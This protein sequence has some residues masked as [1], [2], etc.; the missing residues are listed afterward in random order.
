[1]TSMTLTVYY[2]YCGDVCISAFIMTAETR[3]DKNCLLDS[4]EY[5][6]GHTIAAGLWGGTDVDTSCNGI[7]LVERLHFC[8]CASWQYGSYVPKVKAWAFWFMLSH[9]FVMLRHISTAQQP[10]VFFF[11]FFFAIRLWDKVLYFY[12]WC[13]GNSGEKMLCNNIFIS[14]KLSWAKCSRRPNTIE[15]LRCSSSP[16]SFI[17]RRR[18]HLMEH[19]PQF[20]A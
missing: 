9:K 18:P 17:V 20:Q 4:H 7:I 13:S 16:S 14:F 1:M 8:V 11:F 12:W 6:Q 3:W 10:N 19:F 15:R 2:Q 5:R